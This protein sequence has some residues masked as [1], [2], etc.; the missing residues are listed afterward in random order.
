MNSEKLGVALVLG[1][2]MIA[3][4]V[5]GASWAVSQS[6]DRATNRLAA[7]TLDLKEGGGAARAPRAPSRPGRPDPNKRYDIELGSAPVLGVESAPV[8]VVEWSDFQCPFCTRVWPTL[9]K[10]REEYGDQVRIVFKHLPLPMHTKAPGAHAAAEAAHR[11]G[12]FCEMHD[13][14]FANPAAIGPEQYGVWAEEIG[15]DT[16]QFEVDSQSADVKGRVAA[17]MEQAREVGVTGTPSFFINGRYLSGA[18]PYE[19]F[20]RMIDEEIRENS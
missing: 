4:S 9:E 19:S 15:L 5:L 11:Q 8:T 14:I 12:R 17:D 10:V 18:Q 20:K 2:F 6:L 13:R 7:I 16:D 1:A 3:V